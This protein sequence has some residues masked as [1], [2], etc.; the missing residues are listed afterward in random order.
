LGIAVR[1]GNAHG[2]RLAPRREHMSR[3][4][5][6]GNQSRARRSRKPQKSLHLLPPHL[7]PRLDAPNHLEHYEQGHAASTVMVLQCRT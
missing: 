1:S 4:D 7:L 3:S 2:N 6:L 5:Q